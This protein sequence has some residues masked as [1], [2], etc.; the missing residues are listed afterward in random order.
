VISWQLHIES[1]EA[2]L[3]ASR[4]PSS[5]EI[6]A[7]IKKVNPTTLLLS[8]PDRERGYEAKSQLQNLLL[9]NY[10]ETFH[11]T[12]HPLAENIVL[13]K[14]TA[15][16]SID[17]CHAE[18]ASLSVKA[19]DTVGMP[20]LKPEGKKSRVK[21]NDWFEAAHCFSPKQALEK[22]R[23]LLEEYEYS[24]AEEVLAGVRITT[25]AELA[26]LEK[27]ARILVLEM[28]AYQRAIDTLLAQAKQFI[29]VKTIREL[30]ALAYYHNGRLPEARAIFDALHP[31]ELGKDALYAWVDIC[32]Q[33][34]NLQLA[35]NLS[36]LAEGKEGFV[37]T[38]AGLRK[39]IE[40]GMLAQAEPWL[41]KAEAFLL[42]GDLPQAEKLVQE[43]LG[44]CPSSP[45]ACRIIG[46][47][48]SIKAESEIERLWEQFGQI[49]PGPARLD[50]LTRLSE[51]DKGNSG[52][53]KDLIWEEKTNQKKRM[54]DERLSTLKMLAEQE[55]WPECFG[56]LLW[57]SR[58]WDDAEQC[59]LAFRISPYFTVLYQNRMLARLSDEAAQ[60]LWLSFV[61]VKSLLFSGKTEGCWELMQGMRR[62]FHCYPLFREDYG[63]L[64]RI[65]RD[66]ARSEIQELLGELDKT[67]CSLSQAKRM[68]ARLRAPLSIVPEHEAKHCREAIDR[69]LDRL[70]PA[71]AE[72][73]IEDYREALQVGNAAKAAVL[74]DSLPDKDEVW[75]I[76]VETAA[77]FAVSAEA[78]T[79]SVAPDLTVD[80]ATESTSLT[81]MC[82]S[83]RHRMFRED[84]ETIIIVNLW[85][86]TAIRFTS[87]NFKDLEVMDFLPAD[88]VFLFRD[89]TEWSTVWR[90]ELSE[91]RNR[92]TA[93]FELAYH[94]TF[95]PGASIETV[96]MC[97]GRDNVYYACIRETGKSRI[98]KQCLDVISSTVRSHEI[99]DTLTC[100]FRLSYQPDS[101]VIGT[102]SGTTILDNNL[103]LSEGC[104][105][106][107]RSLEP[108]YL[109]VATGR[110]EIYAVADGFVNVLNSKL[111]AVWQYKKALGANHFNFQSVRGIC[112]VTATVLINL[113][114]N[115]GFFY[116]LETDKFSQ[117][118]SLS[119]LIWTQIP[120]AWY[121][122]NYDQARSAFT[123]KEI[124][125]EVTDLLEWQTLCLPEQ[126]DET[127][128][129]SICQFPPAFTH[130]V[131]T[132]IHPGTAL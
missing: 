11:L 65:E 39:D 81:R 105:P 7:L 80:L 14:H 126:D 107:G 113:A 18:L 51:R 46:Q 93:V 78:I 86:M 106:V 55:K 73:S 97:S 53:I 67:E 96:F 112:P 1:V 88:D 82:S 33:D 103:S 32:F 99:K 131:F 72:V 40:A 22:A 28:G 98:V 68:V 69:L 9:E 76:D 94:F 45:R 79:V 130:P 71:Q 21:V 108:Q 70:K 66:K 95:E 43:A 109:G 24:E 12:P 4:L 118:F 129:A 2:L 104:S 63:R 115:N 83:D 123:I 74:R 60:E 92:F 59:R 48:E 36:D 64:L 125:Y 75:R 47:I 17:A 128:L 41:Q 91:S 121:Y 5:L 13:I 52:K 57:L 122:F 54:I 20:P 19:L 87:P 101:F 26:T 3:Q 56:I 84:D 132:T 8:E 111:R 42:R 85:R 90:A 127:N 35:Y 102:Q 124:T 44:L 37:T 27:A 49:E 30:L 110:R 77:M 119:Q 61:K 6:I 23:Q 117:K 58:H 10:G 116:N 62:Y 15:L 114:V 25:V 89:T 16:P 29:R 50:L 34:G 31:A 38:S 120:S 100:I